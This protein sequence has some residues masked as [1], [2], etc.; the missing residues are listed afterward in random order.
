[1]GLDDLLERIR[2][3]PDD[4]EARQIYAD[5]LL[6][7]GDAMG[8][9]IALQFELARDPSDATLQRRAQDLLLVNFKRWLGPLARC[10]HRWTSRCEKGFLSHAVLAVPAL[11]A[12]ARQAVHASRAWA[13][14][15]SIRVDGGA[16]GDLLACLSS[17]HLTLLE[18]LT[19]PSRPVGA[20]S[21]AN[22]AFQLKR[23]T[24]V[25]ARVDE[26]RPHAA[27]SDLACLRFKLQADAAPAELALL[28]RKWGARRL[29]LDGTAA[30]PVEAVRELLSRWA[31]QEPFPAEIL[32]DGAPRFELRDRSL[33]VQT[34]A[35]RLAEAVDLLRQLSPALPALESVT[36]RGAGARV[37]FEG[38]GP[39][40]LK[41]LA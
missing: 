19:T 16:E 8:E 31:A 41:V 28:A 23:L 2:A 13:T 24:L 29:E 6:E 3:A 32:L 17:P 20:L 37:L 7:R 27:W 38:P 36:V 33:G 12:E 25:E 4:D 5:A 26:L 9:F 35:P 11:D 15:R 39:R 40:L 18:E 10:V 22:L 21:Q 1:M 14:V 34:S 30:E